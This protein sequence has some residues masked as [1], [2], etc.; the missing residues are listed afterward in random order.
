MSNFRI[1][2]IHYKDTF[3]TSHGATTEKQIAIVDINGGL[4]EASPVSYYLT[5]ALPLIS[6]ALSNTDEITQ[7]INNLAPGNYAAKAAIDIALHD[8]KGKTL[9][10]SVADLLNIKVRNNIATSFTIS[11]SKPEIMREQVLKNPNFQIY[12]IK[13]GVPGDMEMVE[14]VRDATRAKIRVD[15][16]AGWSVND[17]INKIKTLEKFNIELIEQPSHQDDIEGLKRIRKSTDIP[18]IADEGIMTLNDVIKYKDAVDGINVKLQK[19][20]GISEAYKMIKKAQ[21]LK[22]KT[23]IGC[24]VETSIGISA[25]AQLAPL[26]DYVDLDGN[27]LISDDPF[28]GVIAENGIL[29][30]TNLPGIGAKEK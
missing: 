15:A 7:T 13:V 3:C 22:M 18:I 17:A 28:L 25:A 10:K 27:L 14:A 11:I 29:K 12:K 20:Y 23:M 19:S 16:N 2:K 1:I 21:D 24:M 8:L 5:R 6:G 26:V 9:N 4:G 30:Y